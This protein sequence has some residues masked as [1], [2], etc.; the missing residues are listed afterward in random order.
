MK[1]A[2]LS[3]VHGNIAALEKIAESLKK[4][5][6]DKIVFL[7]DLIM[8]GPRPI[9]VF[10]LLSEMNPDVWI[11]GN[12]DD[13]LAELP[14]FE[15]VSDREK[16][17]KDM[18][19]WARDRINNSIEKELLSRPISMDKVY[20]SQRLHFCHGT[21]SSHSLAFLPDN[22]KEFLDS[23]LA[24]IRADK[25]VC[26]HT[27]LRFAM[28]F[29]D[30]LIKNFGAVSMPGKDFSRMAHYGIIHIADSI[31]FEDRECEYDFSA[32][33]DDLKNMN[34]PGNSLIFPKYDL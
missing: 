26:G 25:I 1:I 28:S 22:R 19:L 4:E 3:D 17:L 34:Y 5:S 20:A 21:P 9:E 32:Y 27:H 8:T 12:T 31:C 18:G 33:I 23:E 2:V 14:D 24:N 29:R 6:I 11:K 7:G 16:M 13:W 30:K 15:P 10:E